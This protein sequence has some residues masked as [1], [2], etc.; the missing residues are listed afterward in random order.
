MNRIT[1]KVV[2]V[3]VALEGMMAW[4]C[5]NCLPGIMGN[6]TV[7]LIAITS[8]LSRLRP[9]RNQEQT[10]ANTGGRFD[11]VYEECRSQFFQDSSHLL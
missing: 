2:A 3:A 10:L 5:Q 4:M 8:P 6:L 7:K 11:G 9:T 1:V